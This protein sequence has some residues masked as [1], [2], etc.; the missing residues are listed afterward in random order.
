MDM[1]DSRCVPDQ[2]PNNTGTYRV[3]GFVVEYK[4]RIFLLWIS[5]KVLFYSIAHC[6]IVLQ[7]IKSVSL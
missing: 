7:Q 5:G 2:N 4:W 1:F 3:E 6:I